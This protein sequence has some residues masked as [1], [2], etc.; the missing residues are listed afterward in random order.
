[1]NGTKITLTLALLAAAGAAVVL[2]SGPAS[3]A[4]AADPAPAPARV[5]VAGPW[6]APAEVVRWPMRYDRFETLT[7]KDGLPSDHTTCALAHGDEL[8][9]GTDKGVGLRRAG[10]W[11]YLR[12]KDG[13]SHDI[14]TS[15]ARDPETGDWW[16]ST[17]RGLTRI[18]G[19]KPQVYHQLNSG[20]VND[21]VYHVSVDGP[22][23]WAATQAGTS[24]LDTRT[25]AWALWDQRNSIM[26]EPWC[27]AVAHG[28][29]RTWIG[30][31]GGAIIERDLALGMWREYRDPDGEMELDLFRDDG[32]LHEV[33]AF[34]A[35][36]A[37]VLWQ[38]TY[39]GLSRFD[40]RRW[41]TYTAKDTG[42]PG[43]FIQHVAC[44]GHTCWLSTDQGFAVFDGTTC[45]SY[46]RT[47]DGRCAV[48]V[49]RDGREVE[50]TTLAT[51]PGDN[52]VMS[53]TPEPDGAWLATGHGL[54]RAFKA[55]ERKDN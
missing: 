10:T 26:H 45:V 41:N 15:V 19:G 27:Y 3:R 4:A 43:D 22:R 28:P 21:I 42:F 55:I 34:I 31:W 36:D 23:V 54:T 48:S 37:G 2:L 52:F 11:T 30:L 51:A 53:T 33:S 6:D 46:R 16:V 14:V 47:A 18:S 17:V 13:L 7:T 1:M 39:F 32:P 29:G 24:V 9:V 44:K 50:T 12:E 49:A 8:I 25:G 20:L 5:P 35:Y 40:G 38:G